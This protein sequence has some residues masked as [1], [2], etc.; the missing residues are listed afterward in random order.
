MGSWLVRNGSDVAGICVKDH[1]G[2]ELLCFLM[3]NSSDT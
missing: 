2:D 1:A 3:I